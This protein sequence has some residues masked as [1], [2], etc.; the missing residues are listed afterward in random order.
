MSKTE[1]IT[2]DNFTC[3]RVSVLRER[4]IIGYTIETNGSTRVLPISELRIIAYNPRRKTVTFCR[5]DHENNPV[6]STYDPM[7]TRI[8][9]IRL[10]SNPL[11]LAVENFLKR[12]GN[13]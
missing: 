5:S 11:I 1:N 3:T 2:S 12:Q 6:Y 9:A 4:G 8:K 13:S 10:R 7:K